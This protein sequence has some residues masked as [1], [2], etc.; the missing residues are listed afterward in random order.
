MLHACQP[1]LGA[2]VPSREDEHPS[3]LLPVLSLL[4][5]ASL[6][7]IHRLSQ[8][9]TTLTLWLPPPVFS[10]SCSDHVVQSREGQ[11]FPR[12]QPTIGVDNR[13]GQHRSSSRCD[14]QLSRKRSSNNL[15]SSFPSSQSHSESA[16]DP[17]GAM[18][19]LLALL[20]SALAVP[21][22]VPLS[23]L[24][25]IIQYDPVTT[26]G[27]EADGWSWT[28]PKVEWKPPMLGEGAGL[29]VSRAN[30]KFK[31]KFTGTGMFLNGSATANT[32][33]I[34]MWDDK[35]LTAKFEPYTFAGAYKVNLDADGHG[36][37]QSGEHS[38]GLR[39]V[40]GSLA[41]DNIVV[42]TQIEAAY[43]AGREASEHAQ[44]PVLNNTKKNP[45]YNWEGEWDWVQQFDPGSTFLLPSPSLTSAGRR[46][47][48]LS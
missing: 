41:V 45:Q 24:S 14:T 2:E 46:M 32:T 18:L 13:S 16:E 6:F 29:N 34:R 33:I 20:G 10:R 47:A 5:P 9:L 42:Q 3:L 1:T 8:S 35:E 31:T 19:T 4:N 12:L 15:V 17:P 40:N 21:L 37:G 7:Y 30:A 26:S 48:G 43:T 22:S 39:L 28:I 36:F 38:W 23:P 27:D 25:P 11:P 44:E